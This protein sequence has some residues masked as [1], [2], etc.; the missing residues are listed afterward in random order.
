MKI[1]KFGAVLAAL[2]MG[3]TFPSWAGEWIQE[4]NGDWLYEEDGAYATGWQSIDGIWYYLDTE[5]GV[6]NSRPT[7]TGEAASHLLSNK[8][9]EAGLYQDEE[10][11]LVCRVDYIMDGVI[12]ISVGLQ[13]SPNDF[14]VITSYE[15][16]QR[17]GTAEDRSTKI[18]FNLWE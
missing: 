6:L 18:K 11:E 13:S 2:I 17:R 14:T 15:V 9:K 3:C 5:S 12:Y 10:S 16:N 8:L 1:N 4:D 7:M